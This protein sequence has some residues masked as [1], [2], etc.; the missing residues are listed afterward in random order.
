VAFDWVVARN[1]PNKNNLIY[2]IKSMVYVFFCE[3]RGS[4]AECRNTPFR[5]DT[6]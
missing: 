2:L 4:S 5:E 1:I 6:K 3:G